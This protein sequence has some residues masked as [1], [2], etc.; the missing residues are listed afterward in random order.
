[1]NECPSVLCH[2]LPTCWK[3]LF[4]LSLY[5]NIYRILRWRLRQIGSQVFWLLIQME[6][7]CRFLFRLGGY[8]TC[9]IFSSNVPLEYV[10]SSQNLLF[11][12]SRVSACHVYDHPC[13]SNWFPFI[14][15]SFF[16]KNK[17]K[18]PPLFNFVVFYLLAFSWNEI[19]M[20]EWLYK[21]EYLKDCIFISINLGCSKM[22]INQFKKSTFP[23]SLNL[24]FG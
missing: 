4:F 8:A 3:S 7:D 18:K 23:Y 2:V 16:E 1:M 6:K 20:W 9:R 19:E 11:G 24:K 21:R 17:N 14:I 5:Y 12:L 22:I 15:V 10:F 13:S